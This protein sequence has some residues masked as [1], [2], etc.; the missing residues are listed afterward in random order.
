MLVRWVGMLTV[1][2][3]MPVRTTKEFIALTVAH[4][5]EI[6]Y[7]SA[8]NGAYQHLSLSVLASIS[9]I[10]ATHVPF[11]GGGPAV[12]ARVGGEIHAILTPIAEVFPHVNP[13]RLRPIAV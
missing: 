1:H 13:G 12:V 5:G 10:N 7:G 6:L 3:S 2:P 11:K 8:G 9:R 4:P